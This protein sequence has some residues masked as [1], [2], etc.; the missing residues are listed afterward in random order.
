M[1]LASCSTIGPPLTM[2]ER[3]TGNEIQ[4]IGLTFDEQPPLPLRR[5]NSC[6][7]P[8]ACAGDSG[9]TNAE[10]RHAEQPCRSSVQ[11]NA[12][13]ITQDAS[14]RNFSH[15]PVFLDDPE[16]GRNACLPNDSQHFLSLAVQQHEIRFSDKVQRRI[17]RSARLGL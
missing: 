11:L 14:P 3:Q 15:G 8:S 7:H 4:T 16:S 10:Q 12:V 6:P 17:N 2:N 13:F 9:K 5:P 1:P